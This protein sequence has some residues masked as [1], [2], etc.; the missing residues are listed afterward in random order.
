MNDT[1][2]DDDEPDQFVVNIE[3][4]GVRFE[5]TVDQA[6]MV[7]IMAASVGADPPAGREKQTARRG[8]TKVTQ[9]NGAAKRKR[10]TGSPHL[11]KDLDF[12]PK[13]KTSLPAFAA[14]KK[15]ASH[16]QR[17]AVVVFW[18]K[19]EAGV[20][21]KVSL[22]HLNTAYVDMGWRRPTDLGNTLAQAASRNRWFNTANYNDIKL[23]SL[24]ED[25]VRHEL[26]AAAGKQS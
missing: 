2:Q 13:G 20:V 4:P 25:Y 11:V 9:T 26:P 17:L 18:L 3:G 21:S 8:T 7:A 10:R 1:K 22:D 14:A 5:A 24:G 15:P 19:T 6:T 23:T 12:R 16:P